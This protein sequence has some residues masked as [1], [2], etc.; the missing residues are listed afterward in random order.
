[1]APSLCFE[2][3]CGAAEI[4]G[5]GASKL[6]CV[7]AELAWSTSGC[8][9]VAW[10]CVGAS[11]GGS[12][13]SDMLAVGKV[14][15]SG[16]TYADAQHLYAHRSVPRITVQLS[17]CALHCN[18]PLPATH[19]MVSPGVV[20]LLRHSRC[21]R[22]AAIDRSQQC[23]KHTITHHSADVC[24]SQPCLRGCRSPGRCLRAEWWPPGSPGPAG[25]L[26]VHRYSCC[27]T[28]SKA[29]A[30]LTA[31]VG[32]RARPKNNSSAA[33]RPCSVSS[34][35]NCAWALHWHIDNTTQCGVCPC[36][37]SRLR[38]RAGRGRE[39]CKT[40]ELE[41]APAPHCCAWRAC[42]RSASKFTATR[43]LVY[44]RMYVRSPQRHSCT[45]PRPRG[46]AIAEALPAKALDDAGPP[47]CGAAPDAR[48]IR[49][50]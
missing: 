1:M 35:R 5:A 16:V 8:A 47:G 20:N 37:P 19:G 42:R 18:I 36:V 15:A 38:W 25:T 40:R 3:R 34:A 21:S 13:G 14:A 39:H 22:C 46:P 45:L 29:A 30:M 10:P 28:K 6:A 23:T 27:D 43:P 7:L 24:S 11:T 9:T 32:V 4:E 44:E 26:T 33:Q 12:A 2:F 31:A 48:A 17:P 49:V 41:G 50:L